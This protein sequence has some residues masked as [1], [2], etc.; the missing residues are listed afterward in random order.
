[1][2]A[3]G[4]LASIVITSWN[5]ALS[6]GYLTHPHA[7]Q[8]WWYHFQ[9][10]LLLALLDEFGEKVEAPASHSYVR[11]VN[12]PV[13]SA[14]SYS[15]SPLI[16]HGFEHRLHR[17]RLRFPELDVAHCRLEILQC[18]AGM[19]VRSDVGSET[20]GEKVTEWC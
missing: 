7:L 15:S 1:M 20:E 8:D 18:D 12:P 14:E 4:S 11:V 19:R 2:S 6:K 5:L 13:V 3:S 10:Q 9:L 17:A 16:K